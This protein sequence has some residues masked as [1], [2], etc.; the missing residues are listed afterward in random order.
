MSWQTLNGPEFSAAA[1]DRT[2]RKADSQGWCFPTCR[3][4]AWQLIPGPWL[5][6]SRFMAQN[7]KRKTLLFFLS[8]LH[9]LT[10]F[11]L[12]CPLCLLSFHRNEYPAGTSTCLRCL[13]QLHYGLFFHLLVSGLDFMAA[14][15]VTV[16]IPPFLTFL[17]LSWA[18]C[19]CFFPWSYR[20]LQ[21]DWPF[22]AAG[23]IQ[24]SRVGIGRLITGE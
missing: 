8:T 5:L 20:E 9:L 22:S 18:F 14:G 19:P 17:L 12:L 11:A 13:F 15:T 21:R 1:S 7:F 2:P 16:M 23:N 24:L 4:K 6:A 3:Q 10:I